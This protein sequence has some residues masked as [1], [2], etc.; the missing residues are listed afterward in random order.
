[1]SKEKLLHIRGLI[2]EKR[3]DEAR[4]QLLQL[5]EQG[6]PTAQ[7]WLAQLDQIA[8]PTGKAPAPRKKAPKQSDDPKFDYSGD[9]L[10]RIRAEKE[11]VR[12]KKQQQQATQRNI[13]CALRGCLLIVILNVIF[14]LMLPML[15]VAGLTSDSAQAQEI[16]TGVFTFVS[17]QQENPVGRAVTNMYTS[18]SGQAMQ[19][20]IEP[21][22]DQICDIA[23]DAARRNERNTTRAECERTLQ[24]AMTCVTDEF[25]Q[26]ESCLRSY[27]YNRCIGQVGNSA[28][29]QAYCRDFVTTHMGP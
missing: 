6:N 24:E 15:L 18:T 12:E 23:L 10:S 29:G 20:V 28:Q 2:K 11:A 8:P 21:R 27:L 5:S 4:S 17:D 16:T 22:T 1:M 19:S 25:H 13:G 14:F 3:Y 26:A 9:R 7:K